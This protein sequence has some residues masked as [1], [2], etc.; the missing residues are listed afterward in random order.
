MVQLRNLCEAFGSVPGHTK[1]KASTP[2]AASALSAKADQP[3]MKTTWWREA[4]QASMKKHW[5]YF[6][7]KQTPTKK[8]RMRYSSEYLGW[9]GLTVMN[10][11][12]H[13]PKEIALPFWR[14]MI[15]WYSF[16]N[17]CFEAQSIMKLLDMN[18]T[19]TPYETIPSFYSYKILD[20][21]LQLTTQLSKDRVTDLFGSFI[22]LA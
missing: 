2:T 5:C 18:V 14:T 21:D 7:W 3:A 9:L 20:F 16:S 17:R 19:I 11:S 13:S 4:H 10:V 22:T 6:C 8:P 15:A 1:P 12:K